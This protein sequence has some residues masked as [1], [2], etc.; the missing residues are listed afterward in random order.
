MQSR[1]EQG[2]GTALMSPERIHWLPER[3]HWLP[4]RIQ[5]H[6]GC[7]CLTFLQCAF[8]NNPSKR[9]QSHIGCI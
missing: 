4:E 7:I 1:E 2:A 8:S 3:I 6:I 9:I 5:S